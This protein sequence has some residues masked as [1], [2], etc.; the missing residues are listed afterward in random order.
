MN[1]FYFSCFKDC[2]PSIVDKCNGTVS[3]EGLHGL[4]NFSSNILSSV[5]LM[6]RCYLTSRMFSVTSGDSRLIRIIEL[7][8]ETLLALL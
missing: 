1:L 5:Q 7:F 4:D 8:R 6:K 2:T 3:K